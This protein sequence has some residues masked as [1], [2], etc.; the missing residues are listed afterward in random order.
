VTNP[1]IISKCCNILGCEMVSYH[2]LESDTPEIVPVQSVKT[3]GPRKP[4]GRFLIA[5][6]VGI[7]GEFVLAFALM[8]FIPGDT[9]PPILS[10]MLWLACIATKVVVPILMR[11]DG[12]SW[13]EYVGTLSLSTW[14]YAIGG[15]LILV[16]GIRLFEVRSFPSIARELRAMLRM[17]GNALP[18]ALFMLLMQYLYYA[19]EGVLMVYLVVKGSEMIKAWRPSCPV[20]LAGLGGGFILGLTWG[21]PHILSKGSLYIGLIGLLQSLLYGVLY[22]KTRSGLPTWLAWMGFITL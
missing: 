11:R 14:L 12:E 13:R 2:T 8:P 5:F 20:W 15:I 10:I 22:G 19:A 16:L 1:F 21:L 18:L 3:T 17:A 9:I 7:G 4:L 6:A